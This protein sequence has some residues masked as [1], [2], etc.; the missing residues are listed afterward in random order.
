MGIGVRVIALIALTIGCGGRA[1]EETR[2]DPPRAEEST[3][4]EGAADA[5]AASIWLDTVPEGGTLT[6]EVVTDAGPARRVQMEVQEVVR[7][8][9]S[10]AI[11]LAPIGTPLDEEPVFA[12]WLVGEGDVLAGLEQTASLTEPGYAPLDDGGQMRTE[13]ADNIAWRVPRE[14]LTPGRAVGGEEASAGWQFAERVGD[15][16]PPSTGRSCARLE[17]TEA[18]TR[19]MLVVC[20]N[21][22]VVESSR[23]AADG[24]IEERWT[25]VA[26]EGPRAV[27]DD[28]S[29][30][31]H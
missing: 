6:Y 24:A 18:G 2:A 31:M 7:R 25:L 15:L 28:A 17:R 9:A 23:T 26:I 12:R 13:A 20:A 11:L 14:W 21:V 27:T 19:A 3:G 22:G 10:I 1:V 16:A 29:A 30:E 4:G 5:P 8:G